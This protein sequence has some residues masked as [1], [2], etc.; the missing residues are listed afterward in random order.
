MRKSTCE[1]WDG[2]REDRL[3][4]ILAKRWEGHVLPSLESNRHVTFVMNT[5]SPATIG[6]FLVMLAGVLKFPPF[7]DMWRR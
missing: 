5:N 4:I 2:L 7:S 1:G 3:S 6:L